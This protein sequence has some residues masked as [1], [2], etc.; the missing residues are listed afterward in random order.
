MSDSGAGDTVVGGASGI[1]ET[2]AGVGEVATAVAAGVA[3]TGGGAGS[4]GESDRSS[5]SDVNKRLSL[6]LNSLSSLLF[7][8]IWF[9]WSLG[10]L[11]KFRR[12]G[13][14]LVSASPFPRANLF[15][16]P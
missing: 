12:S 6:T 1:G 11:L 2:A 7:C 15:Q 14:T 4:S 3:T 9:T 13:A 16:Q 10:I 5:P 8:A